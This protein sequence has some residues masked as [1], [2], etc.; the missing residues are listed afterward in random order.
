MN[1]I[2]RKV[3]YNIE[4]N[5]SLLHFEC[6]QIEQS[7]KNEILA[8]VYNML[9]ENEKE[10]LEAIRQ[11]EDD[12]KNELGNEL[13]ILETD[14]QQNKKETT[15]EQK[16]NADDESTTEKQLAFENEKD[17][18]IE[19]KQNENVYDNEQNMNYGETVEF[20]YN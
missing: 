4:K 15:N 7:M 12:S 20:K 19:K 1:G 11:T 9:P 5:Q 8:F 3:E 2:V 13:N 14:S 17:I 16:I 18:N 6:T 10:V